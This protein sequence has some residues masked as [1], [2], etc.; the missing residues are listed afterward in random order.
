[1]VAVML[2]ASPRYKERARGTLYWEFDD[3]VIK[4]SSASRP[5]ALLATPL[6]LVMQ[7]M[8]EEVN[9][10]EGKAAVTRRWARDVDSQMVEVLCVSLACHLFDRMAARIQI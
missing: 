3:E 9:G 4:W 7:G 2:W 1:M 5:L 10:S 8:G 6:A